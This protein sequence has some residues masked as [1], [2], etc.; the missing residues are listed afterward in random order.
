MRIYQISINIILP[1]NNFD[2]LA[3]VVIGE[4]TISDYVRAAGRAAA[5]APGAVIKAPFKAA[6]AAVKG[7]TQLPGRAI[8]AAGKTISGAGK[9][10][11]VLGAGQTGGGAELLQS[12]GGKVS[13]AG[14]AIAD[15]PTK[16]HN[17]IVAYGQSSDFKRKYLNDYKDYVNST[18]QRLPDRQKKQIKSATDITE[19][20]KIL[21]GS[22]PGITDNQVK[23]V[24][25][26]FFKGGRI[27]NDPKVKNIFSRT[28]TTTPKSTPVPVPTRTSKK[29]SV[30]TQSTPPPAPIPTPTPVPATATNASQIKPRIKANRSMVNDTAN[31]IIYKYMGRT[32]GGWYIYDPKTRTIDPTP[33]DPQEQKRVGDLWRKKEIANM[34]SRRKK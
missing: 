9:L 12:I 1:M 16:I 29:T 19:I 17:A 20:E 24:T 22:I 27:K 6:K 13:K 34:T 31:G 8:Q 3:K 28:S 23:S 11:N 26:S 5:R 4:S 33:V 18:Y 21:K 32:N 7:V 25:T 2:A 15:I 30:P 14:G 10:Y